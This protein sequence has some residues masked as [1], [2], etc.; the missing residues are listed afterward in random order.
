[1]L[2]QVQLHEQHLYYEDQWLPVNQIIMHPN[3]FSA[4]G[5]ADIAL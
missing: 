5:G 3:Y 4:E 2:F 1:M